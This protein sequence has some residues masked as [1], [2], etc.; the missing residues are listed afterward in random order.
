VCNQLTKGTN[1]TPDHVSGPTPYNLSARRDNR[2]VRHGLTVNQ[3]TAATSS[4]PA[5]IAKPSS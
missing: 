1:A 2:T 4:D 3:L 5:M